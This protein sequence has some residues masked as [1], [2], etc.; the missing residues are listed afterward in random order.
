VKLSVA[1]LKPVLQAHQF[2]NE[3]CIRLNESSVR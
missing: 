1:M 3:Y 2:I